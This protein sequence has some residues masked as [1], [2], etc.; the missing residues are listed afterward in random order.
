[1]KWITPALGLCL[2]GAGCSEDP[3]PVTSGRAASSSPAKGGGH[4]GHL[5]TAPHGGSL[6]ILGETFA[7]LE[8]L[9]DSEAGTRLL[10]TSVRCS[11]PW[12][13][14]GSWQERRS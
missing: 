11:G 7:H 8:L 6:V 4:S 10:A 9:L 3:E 13:T 14:S 1:M 2:A 5:H 12:C